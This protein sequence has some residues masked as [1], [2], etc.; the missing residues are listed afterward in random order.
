MTEELMAFVRYVLRRELL[1]KE[2]KEPYNQE[3]IS[4]AARLIAKV[5]SEEKRCSH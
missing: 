1:A 5:T 3:Y 2:S 4:K